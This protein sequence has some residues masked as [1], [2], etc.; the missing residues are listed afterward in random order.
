MA[1]GRLFIVSA[2]SGTGK[3]TILKK[4]MTELPAL[5]FSVSHTTRAPRENESDGLDYHFVNKAEFGK[6]R[7]QGEFLESAEVHG[8]LYG[9]RLGAVLEQLAAGADVILDIDVQGAAQVKKSK[10][11]EPVTIFIIPPSMA[12]L[13][14]RLGGRGT[15]SSETIRLRLANA[16]AEMAGL[17]TYDHVIV[18]DELGEALEMVKAVILAERS[19]ARR[20]RN[21]APIPAVSAI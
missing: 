3:T 5:A 9:T 16:A 21:G 11:I 14:K 17:E 20:T 2:P 7:D 18:N 8:N 12:E 19:R 15:D 13:E 10:K 6:M 4:L 1:E